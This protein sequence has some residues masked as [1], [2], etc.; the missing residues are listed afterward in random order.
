M[1]EIGVGR[2]STYAATISTITDRGYVVKQ[3]SALV[4][5]WLAFGVNRVLE[6]TLPDYVNYDYTANMEEDLDRISRGEV[7][8][9]NWLKDYW[10]GDG[11]KQIGLEKETDKLKKLIESRAGDDVFAVGNSGRYQIRVT[12][13]GPFVEDKEG[14][15][16]TEGRFPRGYLPLDDDKNPIAPDLLTDELMEQS[17]AQG[18]GIANN[19]KVL[20]K[21]PATGFEVVAITGKYGPY[22]TEILPD[23]VPKKG[24]GAVK[25][26]TASL[27]KDMSIE[28]VDIDDAL[29]VLQLP[30]ELGINPVDQQKIV[31]N[32]GRFGPYLMKKDLDTKKY[33]YRSIKKTDTET[34]EDRMFTVT[35]D[36]AIEVYSKPKVYGRRGGRKK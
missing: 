19:G 31:V 2:P 11:K 30:K 16:D 17:V 5:T 7:K 33:D 26:K 13:Y 21:N 25:A 27:L 32:N 18:V 15:P 1:E 3:G 23:D 8:R 20:G 28:T 9:N 6:D 35:L 4:P 14:I 29:K 12:S 24:K 22:F 10:F 36:E 34:A